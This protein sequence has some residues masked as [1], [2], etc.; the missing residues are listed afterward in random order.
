MEFI[1]Y[2]PLHILAFVVHST[3]GGVRDSSIDRCLLLHW[4]FFLLLPS[5]PFQDIWLSVL[6]TL[7]QNIKEIHF[8]IFVVI[9]LID[10]S[11]DS[12]AQWFS[13]M[14]VLTFFKT[15]NALLPIE[16]KNSMIYPKF[17]AYVFL[18]SVTRES[19][20]WS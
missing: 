2:A 19:P 3:E 1:S 20:L 10:L 14:S 11:F 13:C 17:Y 16:I 12:I 8:F 5:P 18:S 9:P 15:I 4:Y 6:I 7:P